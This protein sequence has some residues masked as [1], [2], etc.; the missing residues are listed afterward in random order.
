MAYVHTSSRMSGGKKCECSR[1]ASVALYRVTVRFS[2]PLVPGV[3]CVF[4]ICRLEDGVSNTSQFEREGAIYTLFEQEERVVA[5]LYCGRFRAARPFVVIND[6]VVRLD[7]R[8]FG[9][10]KEV[11]PRRE[12]VAVI[13]VY[14][15]LIISVRDFVINRRR[16]LPRMFLIDACTVLGRLRKRYGFVHWD[17]HYEN[18]MI[19]TSTGAFHVL[20]FDLST[21][22]LLASETEVA[23]SRTPSL[24]SVL[25]KHAGGPSEYASMVML[26]P[27]VELLR[28]IVKKSEARSTVGELVVVLGHGYDKLMIYNGE[29]ECHRKLKSMISTP[30]PNLVYPSDYRTYLTALQTIPKIPGMAV[31]CERVMDTW[32]LRKDLEILPAE[33]TRWREGVTTHIHVLFAAVIFVAI[34]KFSIKTQLLLNI[35]PELMDKWYPS[36]PLKHSTLHSSRVVSKAT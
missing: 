6:E 30:V 35:M 3:D 25:T 24:R 28:A 32:I 27:M 1:A 22:S 15:P 36:V 18:Q 26:G 34:G 5:S 4:K 11:S 33:I 17:L 14:N 16:A 2:A 10:L 12:F 9:V 23:M 19:D 31:H 21:I 8:L 13:T 29:R 20:D 7:K